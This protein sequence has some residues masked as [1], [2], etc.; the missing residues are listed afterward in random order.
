M[1][2]VLGITYDCLLRMPR[3]TSHRTKLSLR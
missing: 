3:N 2:Y 1:D